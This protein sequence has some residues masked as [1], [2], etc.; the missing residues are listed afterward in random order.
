MGG[1]KK[2]EGWGPKRDR[3]ARPGCGKQAGEKRPAPHRRVEMKS[4]SEN[5]AAGSD[6]S[7]KVEEKTD[8]KV[9]ERRRAPHRRVEM[10]SGSETKQRGLT[11]VKRLGL[12]KGLEAGWKKESITAAEGGT[13]AT[14]W[15][16][17]AS[18]APGGAAPREWLW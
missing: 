16:K 12:E 1:W 2:K 5:K 7:K 8:S 18:T 14:G 13:T 6:W 3:P 17:E 15:G 11:G 9:G 10:K 4:G